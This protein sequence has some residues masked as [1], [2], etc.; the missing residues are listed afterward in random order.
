MGTL[1]T[2]V[3]KLTMD[4]ADFIKGAQDTGQQGGFLETN[5]LG[6]GIAGA[7][8]GAGMEALARQQAPL[9]ESTKKLAASMDMTEGEMRD[10][11]LATTDVT[12]PLEDVLELFETGRQRGIEGSEALKEYAQFWDMVGDAT[13]E[14]ATKLA[15]SAVAMEQ[16]GISTDNQAEALGALGYIAQETTAEVDDF[17][18]FVGRV[19]SEMGDNTPHIDDMA[20][21]LGALEDSGYDA[22]LAQRELRQ[23]LAKTDGNM[24][25]ALELLGISEEQFGEYT[26]AVANSGDVIERNA[27]IHGE[28]YTMME[29]LQQKAGE[30]TYRYGDLIGVVGNFAPLMMGLGPILKGVTMAKKALGAVSLKAVVPGFLAAAKGAWAFTAALLA[31]PITWIIIAIIALIAA[32]YLLW[33]NWDEVSAWLVKAWDW[34]KDKATEIWGALSDFFADI[35]ETIIGFFTNAWE[36]IKELFFNLHP[37]GWVIANWEEVQEFFVNIFEAIADFF[38]DV[39]ERITGIFSS[40]TSGIFDGLKERFSETRDWVLNL[41]ESVRDF[42]IGIWDRITGIFD[43]SLADIW[44]LIKEWFGAYLT[45]TTDI[46]QQIYDF[47]GGLW[48]SIRDYIGGVLD[49]IFDWFNSWGG[50]MTTSA[51]ESAKGIFDTIIAWIGNLPGELL[52]IGRNMIANLAQGI[53]DRISSVTSAVKD[54]ATAVRN[55]LPFSPA[56]E[57]PLRDIPDFASYILSGIQSAESDAQRAMGNMLSRVSPQVAMA[58]PGQSGAGTSAAGG[59]AGKTT[60]NNHYEIGQLVVREEADVEKIAKQLHDLQGQRRRSS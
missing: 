36:T 23:A 49:S 59:N 54:T 30:L 9:T 35:W 33:T 4:N 29:K 10:L 26:D 3:A 52:N 38:T 27:E 31:N 47:I 12:F 7:A 53:R 5:M 2:L 37:L 25:Q 18:R 45:F 39:W 32:I 43:M 46:N 19:G 55:F 48:D 8:A 11:A 28:S 56:K 17:L 51:S 21:A 44:G 24:E 42:F 1:G 60:V 22:R 58:T 40:S 14:S 57:G 41:W 50:D 15:E 20:A 6:I 13:G 34:I 16:A